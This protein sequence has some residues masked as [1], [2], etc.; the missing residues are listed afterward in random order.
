[1]AGRALWGKTDRESGGSDSFCL[2]NTSVLVC[3]G[4]AGLGSPGWGVFSG[5]SL[6]GGHWGLLF[7]L[8]CQGVDLA[9]TAAS[10]SLALAVPNPWAHL[11]VGLQP[12]SPA[13][14]LCPWR[15]EHPLSCQP[16]MCFPRAVLLSG[17]GGGTAHTSG[18][19]FGGAGGVFRVGSL[20]EPQGR[21]TGRELSCWAGLSGQ[22]AN[23]RLGP[24]DQGTIVVIRT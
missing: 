22:S 20:Q 6:H 3:F 12:P 10:P 2:Q 16:G 4:S 11:C 8:C 14:G 23:A 1:M 18:R 7:A 24:G 19:F 21:S 5:V 9:H 15:A 17:Q 13:V